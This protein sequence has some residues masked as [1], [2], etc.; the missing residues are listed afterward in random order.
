MFLLF[1]RRCGQ[2]FLIADLFQPIDDLSVE[3]FLNGDVAHPRRCSRLVPMFFAG[4]THDHIAGADFPL[5][6]VP[7][8][9]PAAAGGDDEFLADTLLWPKL[10]KFLRQYPDIRVEIKI[11]YGLTDIV[12]ERFDAG[13]RSGEQVAKDMIAVRI[14]PDMRM[15]VVGA[16]SYFKERSEPKRPQELIGHNCINLRLPTH[17]GLYA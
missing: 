15:A 5:R 9:H 2:I 13:V 7:T 6:S 10:A 4:R 1:G 14:G 8:P 3:R 17:G 12:A 11:D 16:P